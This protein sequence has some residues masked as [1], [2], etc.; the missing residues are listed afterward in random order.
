MDSKYIPT[1]DE[2]RGVWIAMTQSPE[3]FDRWLYTHELHKK[4]RAVIGERRRVLDI[5]KRLNFHSMT[6]SE[7]CG[8]WH[9]FAEA[10]I[11]HID[12]VPELGDLESNHKGNIPSMG[13]NSD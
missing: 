8:P 11:D 9:A 2:V 12:Y 6:H 1:T 4:A 7:R 5:I 10:A 3:S 13:E